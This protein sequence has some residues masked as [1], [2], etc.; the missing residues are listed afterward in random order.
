MKDKSIQCLC[1]LTLLITGMLLYPRIGGT[2][3]TGPTESIQTLNAALLDAMKRADDLGY[4]GRYKLLE[5][6]I[7]DTFAFTFMGA[8]S[9]GKFWDTMSDSQRKTFIDT[10]T[11]W[12]IATYAG[13]FDGYS[14]ER[15]DLISQSP[16]SQGTVSVIVKLVQVNEPP[17]TFNYLM[18]FLEDHWRIVDIQVAGV[19]QLALTRAQFTDVLKNKN[20]DALISLLKSKIAGFANAKKK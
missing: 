12:S 17:I 14:G 11:D 3:E 15:F 4:E 19:S 18:K 7:R 10:Y 9:V 8:R 20:Y 13:R 5:P 1:I 6:V 16:P 2:G